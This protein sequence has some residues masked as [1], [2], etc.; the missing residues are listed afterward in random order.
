MVIPDVEGRSGA[1][2]R[3]GGITYDV[4]EEF[5]AY[6]TELARNEDAA[7]VAASRRATVAAA[8]MGAQA[9][10][11]RRLTTMHVSEVER[12][13]AAYSAAH[14]D[15]GSFVRRRPKDNRRYSVTRWV[16]LGADTG[17]VLGAL[18][19][20][21]EV[22]LLALGTALAVGLSGVTAGMVGGD[23]RELKL[24][25]E[26]R[27]LVESDQIDSAIVRRYPRLF[28]PAA[29]DKDTYGLAIKGALV[30]VLFVGLGIFGIRAALEGLLGVAFFGF[31]MAVA[32]ASFISSWAHADDVADVLEVLEARMSMALARQR[33]LAGA[34][35]PSAQDAHAAEAASIQSEHQI[36]GEAKAAGVRALKH[37]VYRRHPQIFGHGMAEFRSA[38]LVP[39]DLADLEEVERSGGAAATGIRNA[40]QSNGH[41][42]F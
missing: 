9:D 20:V 15:L 17:A 27:A 4:G 30:V 6:A 18:I 19:Y 16:L 34:P 25:R 24:A 5:E 29:P 33:A 22:P 13:V 3:P 21:G 41:P 28:G 7:G 10:D 11:A 8:G 26:R 2:L 14:D 39:V 31:A 38:R 23:V 35:Q 36:R 12:A 42:P 32:L 1:I 37:E 40:F